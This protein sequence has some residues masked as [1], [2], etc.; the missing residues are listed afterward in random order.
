MINGQ[1]VRFKTNLLGRYVGRWLGFDLALASLAITVYY[2]L[3][4]ANTNFQNMSLEEQTQLLQTG[5]MSGSFILNE[6]LQQQREMMKST[7]N[8]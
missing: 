2:I 3:E 5:Q 6:L 4:T 7:N 1:V 8:N